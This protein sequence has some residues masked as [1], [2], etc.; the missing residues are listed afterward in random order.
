MKR[1]FSSKVLAG[2]GKVIGRARAEWNSR[3]RNRE[4]GSM[5]NNG[6]EV[7]GRVIGEE[8]L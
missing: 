8:G 5:M 3:W 1:R 4:M 6:S 2:E 7:L